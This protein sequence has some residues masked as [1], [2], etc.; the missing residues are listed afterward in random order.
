MMDEEQVTE[1]IAKLEQI[2]M[3]LFAQLSQTEGALAA[4]K[5]VFDPESID[6]AAP[7]AEVIPLLNEDPTLI[8]VEEEEE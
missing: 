7:E 6:V 5:A 3:Q 1:E 4:M 2:R 8:V